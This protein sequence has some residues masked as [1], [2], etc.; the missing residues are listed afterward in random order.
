MRGEAVDENL[1][2]RREAEDRG[3]HHTFGATT[4]NDLISASFFR[5]LRG[6]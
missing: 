4:D 5:L 3:R 2:L 6:F 1:G